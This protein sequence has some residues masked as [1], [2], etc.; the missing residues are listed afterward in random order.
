VVAVTA[1]R[2]GAVAVAEH[3]LDTDVALL[4]W[5]DDGVATA[6]AIT[7]AITVA[8]AVAVAITVAITVAVAVTGS[9]S[10]SPGSPSPSP[11]SL[12]VSAR[13]VL[14]PPLSPP[15][16][17]HASVKHGRA[18]TSRQAQKVGR[19]MRASLRVRAP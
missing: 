7:V 10:P 13:T 5:L 16:S 1:H 3:G 19:R 17:A 14:K 6:N 2:V 15:S 11:G 12:V 4:A 9:P 8:V 18:R